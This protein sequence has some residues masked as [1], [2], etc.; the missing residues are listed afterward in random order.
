MKTLLRHRPD[1]PF[2]LDAIRDLV[3]VV[4]GILGAL[5]LESWW[6]GLEDRDTEQVILAGLRDEFARNRDDLAQGLG[7]LEAGIER[8]VAIHELIGG[9]V[10][11]DR[12]AAFRELWNA[13]HGLSFFDPRQG[14][15]SSVISSGQLALIR[16]QE[17]RAQIAD[18]PALAED[19]DLER[20][21]FLNLFG[22]TPPEARQV[23]GRWSDS[24][25]EPDYAALL[26][27]RVFDEWLAY[28]VGNQRRTVEESRAILDATNQIIEQI[29]GELDSPR[30]GR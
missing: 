25:F 19:L 26:A 21:L 3:I 16:N 29:D 22:S 10:D 15:L 2:L 6:Q 20:Q 4:V 5:W 11:T 18:W 27:S 1:T 8:L 30:I 28:F 23:I 7:P 13:P 17:L 9:S 24:A 14:Q 12:L